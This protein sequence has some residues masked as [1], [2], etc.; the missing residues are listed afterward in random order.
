M[1]TVTKTRLFLAAAALLVTP[2]LPAFAGVCC[3]DGGNGIV[4][5]RGLGESSP[6]ATN[7]STDARWAVYQFARGGV[8]Y[9]QINDATGN[10]KAAVGSIGSTAW[11]LPLGSD[12]DRVL[13]P[14]DPVPAGT[15]RSIFLCAKI[16][17]IVI[18]SATGRYWLIVPAPLPGA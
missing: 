15:Q 7:V 14:G 3:P 16:Q 5:G 9:T 8:D 18:E 1:I 4:G 11:V 10:V 13:L 2:A 12:A 6:N 17:V